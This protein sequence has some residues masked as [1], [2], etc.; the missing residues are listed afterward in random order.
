ME[1]TQQKYRKTSFRLEANG[2]VSRT[3][4]ML[5]VKQ[6]KKAVRPFEQS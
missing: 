4:F 6:A 2:S 5:V 3:E 1:E